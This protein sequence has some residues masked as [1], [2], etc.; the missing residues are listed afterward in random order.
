LGST[1]PNG[2]EFLTLTLEILLAQLPPFLSAESPQPY[3][4][5]R[6][7]RAVL[8]SPLTLDSR[9]KCPL[10]HM[11]VELW[12]QQACEDFGLVSATVFDAA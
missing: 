3:A 5:A 11:D 6:A 10:G 12:K 1:S 9:K 7:D 4:V 8:P 2:K